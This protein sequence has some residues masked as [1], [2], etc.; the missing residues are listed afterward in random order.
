MKMIKAIIRP[1]RE[2]E[3]IKALEAEGL[4]AL[5]KVDVL[6]RGQQRGIQIGETVYDELAKLMLMIVV[7]DKDCDRAVKAIQSAAYTGHF[8]D[9]R[10]FVLPVAQARTIRTGEAKL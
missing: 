5:T 1:E 10:I 7:E 6:G 3:A 9:G 8:G 4:Y 2:D